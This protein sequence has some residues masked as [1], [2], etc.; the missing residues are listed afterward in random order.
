MKNK[1]TQ[2]LKLSCSNDATVKDKQPSSPSTT[3]LHQCVR[4]LH[5]SLKNTD[6]ALEELQQQKEWIRSVDQRL[7]QTNT[8]LNTTDII[9]TRIEKPFNPFRL[10]RRSQPRRTHGKRTRSTETA[11]YTGQVVK[12]S[13]W[14]KKWR[15]RM[16]TLYPST[17]E[18]QRAGAKSRPVTIPLDTGATRVYTDPTQQILMLVHRSPCMLRFPSQA[19][20]S[21]IVQYL[22]QTKRMRVDLMECGLSSSVSSNPVVSQTVDAGHVRPLQR[23]SAST[24]DQ[25]H[26][27]LDVL[28]AKQQLVSEELSSQNQQLSHLEAYSRQTR[29][30]VQTNQERVRKKLYQ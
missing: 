17:F 28:S 5:Q 1:K 21:L 4:S 2:Y 23:S 19:L 26:D 20:Y 30:R 11:V 8:A 10:V 29:Q 15:P 27:C 9:L 13:V 6:A 3:V 16:F 18:L 7:H 22:K 14:F 12:R 25:I 24:L